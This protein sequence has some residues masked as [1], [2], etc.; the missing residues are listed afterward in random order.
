[1]PDQ[2]DLSVMQSVPIKTA[3]GFV[4]LHRYWRAPD[5]EMWDEIW[6]RLAK[7]DY[8]RGALAGKLNSAY[9]KAFFRYLNRGKVLEA[10]CG[11]G[12]VVLAL[13]ARGIDCHGLDYAQETIANLNET[14]PDVPFKHGD[15]R[16]LPYDDRYFDGYISLGVIEHFVDGQ[17]L[18]LAEAARVLK[19]GAYAFVSV[20]VL[21]GFR[22]LRCKLNTYRTS[23][24]LPFFE[25]CLS[26]DELEF[27][28][29]EAG[30]DCVD[31]IYLNPVMTFMQ[32][33]PL[34]PI[35]R[36][37]EDVRFV[38]GV[39]DRLFNFFLPKSWFGHMVMM[40]AKKRGDL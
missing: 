24:D 29:S 39:V 30:F 23:A 15:V 36:Q 40:V 26:V 17:D 3:K 14:F 16:S 12:Q 4:R 27:L 10:G 20:P 5:E 35:Y 6:G 31:V 13:R 8:W 25:S 21:N 37:I 2:I 28:L 7:R 19:P 1:M 18:M 9:E 11:V 33:T 32:E 34:R 22:R 38:R